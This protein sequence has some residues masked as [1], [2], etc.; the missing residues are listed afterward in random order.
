[1]YPNE[2]RGSVWGLLEAQIGVDSRDFLRHKP[3]V[4]CILMSLSDF[5]KINLI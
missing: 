5:M 3:F 2:R 1:M 4:G